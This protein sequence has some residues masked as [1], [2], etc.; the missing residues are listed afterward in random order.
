MEYAK[1]EVFSI[2]YFNEKG[3]VNYKTKKESKLINFLKNNQLISSMA[4]LASILIIVNCIF[5]YNFWTILNSTL[6]FM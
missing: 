1:D 6:L 5:L 4:A 2:N 3:E